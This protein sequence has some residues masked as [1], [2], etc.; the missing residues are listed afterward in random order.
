MFLKSLL[1]RAYYL[2]SP[3]LSWDARLK[4]TGA[5]LEKI[6]DID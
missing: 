5:K 6:S 1:L 3:G 2:S 4:M